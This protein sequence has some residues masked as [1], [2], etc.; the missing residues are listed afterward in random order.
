LGVA[1]APAVPRGDRFATLFW[2]YDPID[3]VGKPV[4]PILLEGALEKAQQA[5]TNL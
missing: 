3:F 2:R 4:L 1:S 5:L